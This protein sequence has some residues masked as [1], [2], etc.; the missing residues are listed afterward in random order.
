LGQSA[1][2]RWRPRVP[3]ARRDAIAGISVAFVL[4]PQ[5]LAYAQLAGLPPERG[6]Y[7]AALPLIAA[8]LLASS[9]YLQ[10]G[11]TAGT[12]LLVLGTVS[13]MAP[14]G[15]EEYVLLAALLA[16][17]VGAWRLLLGLL[18]GGPFA[19]LLSQPVLLGFTVGSGLLI[20]ASQLPAVFGVPAAAANPLSSAWRALVEPERWNRCG[21]VRGRRDARHR[22]GAACRA[23]VS[24][25]P[26]GD[27]RGHRR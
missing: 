18:R 5:S 11:P 14:V 20:I 23:A 8:A 26:G 22:G 9:P 16:V 13:A 3:T 17:L 4:I 24:G 7:A 12:A 25:G 10:T 19:Y 6:L 2:P 15:G 27:D 21:R 1:G